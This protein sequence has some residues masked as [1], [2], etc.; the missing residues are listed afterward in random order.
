[1]L[2]TWRQTSPEFAGKLI[3]SI[4]SMEPDKTLKGII[5]R[6]DSTPLSKAS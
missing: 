3:D 5:E 4:K 1:V 6:I 2:N